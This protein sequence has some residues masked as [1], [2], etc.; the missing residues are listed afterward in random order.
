MLSK[1]KHNFKIFKKI[2][3][4]KNS[5]L[6]KK[7]NKLNNLLKIKLIKLNTFLK[8]KLIKLNFLSKKKKLTF[9]INNRASYFVLGVIFFIL[10]YLSIPYFYNNDK[11]INKV[12][13]ELSKNLNIDFNLSE[14]FSYRFFPRPYFTFEQVSFLNQFKN[15]GKIK[16]DIPIN[17]LLFLENLQIKDIILSNVNFDVNKKNY[18][19]FTELLKNDFSNFK[20]EIKNS[21]IFYRNTKNDVLFINKIDYLKYYYDKKK[22]SNFFIADNEIFNLFYNVKFNN[23]F[24]NKK[25]TS[26]INSSSLNLKTEIYLDYKKLKKKEGLIN[27]YYNKKKINAKYNYSKDLFEF[28]FSDRPINPNFNYEGTINLKPFFLE[29]SGLF[30]KINSKEFLN[31]NSILLQFLKTEI[32]NNKNL[33][34]NTS[35]NVKQIDALED[36]DNVALKVKIIEG[37][38]DINETT[39]SWLNIAD[40]KI[41]D[42]LIFMNNNNLVLDALITIKIN[43]FQEFYKFFQTPRN[44]RKEVKNIQFNLSYNFDQF[45]ADLNDIRIDGLIDPK[46]NKSLKKLILKNNK[47]QNRIYFKNLINQAMKFYAG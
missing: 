40:L 13:S 6:K 8:I 27:F 28:N 31:P 45:T 2:D 9:K 4:I 47:L 22:L 43:N 25:I 19:F 32:L 26:V 20:F 1:F 18:N 34:M 33:N 39:L 46:V 11:L 17:K 44:H 36:L 21:N 15:S 5:L 42:S 29:S 37:L 24:V 38:I 23:D 16:V 10:S 41:S 12:E 30:K 7:L 3:H 35:L 14:N